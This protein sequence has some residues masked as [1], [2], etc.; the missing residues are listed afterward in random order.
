MRQTGRMAQLLPPDFDLGTLEHSERRVCAALVAGL[1]D[2]WLVVPSVPI[3]VDGTDSEIDVVLVSPTHGAI[4]VE[5]KGGAIS[6]EAGRWFQNGRPL[7]KSPTDQVTAAKHHLIRRMRGI[8]LDLEGLFLRHVVALPDVGSVPPEGLGPDAPAEIIFTK[9]ELAEPAYA[10]AALHREHGPIPAERLTRF[11]QALRPDL[12]LD[13][14]GGRVMSRTVHRIDASTRTHLAA[15]RSLDANRRV[16]VTGGAG[17]GKTW[18]VIDW[19]RRAVER[20][21]RT[22]VVC[23]NK[24]IADYLQ[25]RLAETP[26]MVGTYHDIVSR[27]LEPFDFVIPRDPPTSYWETAPTAA[28]MARLDQVGAPFDTII[29]DEGQDLRPHWWVSLEALMD[30]AGTQRLLMTADPAQAIYVK[31]FEPPTGAAVFELHHNL[32]SS[33]SVADVVARLGGPPPLPG[34]PGRVPVRY[35]SAGGAKERRKRVRDLVADLTEVQGVPRSQI[36]VLTLRTWLRD[37]LL[38]AAAEHPDELPLARWEHRSEDTVLC[39]TV[40]RTKG[41]ERAAV[42][43][44]GGSDDADP[45]LV[46]IGA[47]RAIWSLTLVGQAQLAEIAGLST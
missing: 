10:V 4:A 27:L 37:E 43:V 7:A 14:D 44:V 19:A 6:L 32:R 46:Y 21:E 15:I 1:D 38:E 30:P 23:F 26:A 17:T 29:V 39:E 28:L 13:T 3:C 42:I 25:R 12:H 11:V 16:L 31:P 41:L 9:S 40:H 35:I 47:S 45:Q 20:G 2:D 18:L 33:A 36:L 5:V 24:P 8:G 34:S 22:L